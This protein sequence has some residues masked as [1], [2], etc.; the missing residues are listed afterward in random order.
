M[1]TAEVLP[2]VNVDEA[3]DDF[4]VVLMVY[5]REHDLHMAYS[6]SQREIDHGHIP[7]IIK[8]LKERL[9]EKIDATSQGKESQDP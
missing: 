5:A 4:E 6:L 2:L 3:E 7:R 8:F 1:N 9:K